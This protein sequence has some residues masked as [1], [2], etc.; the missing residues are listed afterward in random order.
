M[1]KKINELYLGQI[2][3]NGLQN[4][5]PQHMFEELA[6]SSVESNRM[7]ILSG[8]KLVD[9]KTGESKL[10]P[11]STKRTLEPPST[12]RAIEPPRLVRKL[13]KLEKI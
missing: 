5:L 13:T 9:S 8:R 2:L 1:Q 10:P 6:H 7:S 4:K 11:L 3:S 12:K